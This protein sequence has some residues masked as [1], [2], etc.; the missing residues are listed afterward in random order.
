MGHRLQIRNSPE[1]LGYPSKFLINSK[2]QTAHS[3]FLIIRKPSTIMMYPAGVHLAFALLVLFAT[4]TVAAAQHTS[5]VDPQAGASPREITNLRSAKSKPANNLPPPWIAL[6]VNKSVP[7]LEPG[8]ECPLSQVVSAVSQ[9]MKELVENLQKFD[10][11]EHLEHFNVGVSGPRGKPETRKFDYVAIITPLVHGGFL[12]EEYRNG[13]VGLSQFPD[14]I[15]TTGL[16]AM[17]LIFHPIHVSN[18]NVTCEGLG[19]WDGRPAWL[20]DFAQRPDRPNGFSSYVIN[21]RVYP[22]PLKGRAWIDVDSYQVRRLETE[23][24]KPIPEI[25]LS[26]QDMAI[27]YG[28]VQFRTNGQQLWLP[29]DAE[30]YSYQRKHRFYRRHTLSN[31]KLFEVET[32]EQIQTPKEH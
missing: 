14:K 31:F 6:G 28:P 29:L 10:A 5:Q 8:V 23:M 9:R 18:F 30:L 3:C 12:V 27:D 20:V 21:D 25:K 13:T 15:A 2:H 7:S 32:A 4:A 11:T 19:Q 22:V 1:L 26:E 24:M 16:S 17:A